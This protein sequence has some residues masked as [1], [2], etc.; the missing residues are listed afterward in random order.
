MD[1]KSSNK[2]SIAQFLTHKFE[3]E[4]QALA[5]KFNGGGFMCCHS[6]FFAETGI[7]IEELVPVF[8]KLDAQLAVANERRVA[9]LSPHLAGG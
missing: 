8:Q 1:A 9:V 4:V 6:Q 3:P 5:A 7:W 2:M